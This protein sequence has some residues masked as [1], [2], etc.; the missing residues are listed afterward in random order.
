MNRTEKEQFVEQLK[1]DLAKAKSVV[2]LSHVGMDANTVADLRSK[3]RAA[4]VNY[5]VVKNTLA[6]IAI[7]GTEMET[8]IDMFRGPTAIAYSFEDA[9][10]PARIARDFAK[11]HDVYEIRGA[12]LE[13]K[14]FDMDGVK[15]LA[16]MPTKEELQA[17]LLGLFQAV[18][19][20]LLRT[21]NAA[22]Q[23]F[24]M[25]LK[26]KAEQDAA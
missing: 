15:T 19:A 16:D 3:Y 24:L 14:V 5:R 22:P 20:K 6:R 23:T 2:L 26:A 21:L 18:P 11:E 10:S 12:F 8:I 9:V 17:K 1:G 4:D 25:V 7:R 13:G